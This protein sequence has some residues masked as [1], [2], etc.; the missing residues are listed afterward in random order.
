MFAEILGGKKKKESLLRK[1]FTNSGI[2]KYIWMIFFK[3]RIESI[4]IQAE[5]FVKSGHFDADN[6]K[7]KQEQ[8]VQRYDSLQVWINTVVY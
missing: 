6:I 2:F 7:A 1:K 3:D 4:V 5:Q 8:V